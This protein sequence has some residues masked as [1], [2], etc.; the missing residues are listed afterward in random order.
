MP[1]IYIPNSGCHDF[2]GA[3]QYGT[4]TPI[5][6]GKQNLLSIGRM[7]REFSHAMESASEDDLIL[8][9]GPAVMSA[10][11]CTIF[12]QRFGR[13][14]LLLYHQSRDGISRYKIRNIILEKEVSS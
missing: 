4:L 5:T 1:N 10:L 9:C 12:A 3:E 14:N 11:L 6:K 13:L 7:Y 2:S 8:I